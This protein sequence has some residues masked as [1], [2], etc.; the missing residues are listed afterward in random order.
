MDKQKCSKCGLIKQLNGENFYRDRRRPSGY[1]PECKECSKKARQ[2]YIYSCSFCGK[3]FNSRKRDTENKFCSRMCSS[4]FQ[5][6]LTGSKSPNYKGHE[7]KKICPVCK[8]EYIEPRKGRSVTCSYECA[9]IYAQRRV[10]LICDG[11]GTKFEKRE[12]EVY[13]HEKRGHNEHF[14][15]RT[16][17]DKHHRGENN[18]KWIKDR[19]KI[20]NKKYAIR[21]SYEM[22]QWRDEVYKRDNYTCQMCGNRSSEGNHLELNA[23]HI[24]RFSDYPGLRTDVDNG[25]TLCE[26]CHKKTYCK[27]EDYEDM[28]IQIIEGGT[29]D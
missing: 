24:K 9:D 23:H 3:K 1:K 4:Q 14:C 27:E 11:C 2:R 19:S 17:K 16:C 26:R 12:S 21:F 7:R 18:P 20:K 13:W 15:N 25:I 8:N 29:I 10:E 22:N 28:F 5:K 6:T